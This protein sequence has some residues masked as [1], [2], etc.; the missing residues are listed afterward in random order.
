MILNSRDYTWCAEKFV[1]QVSGKI[2]VIEYPVV[3]VAGRD[4]KTQS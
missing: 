4:E 2:C 3:Y 1:T